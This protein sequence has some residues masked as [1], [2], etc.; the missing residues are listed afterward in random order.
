M[1]QQNE[2]QTWVVV[3]WCESPETEPGCFGKFFATYDDAWEF[4][5]TD[6]RQFKKR[7]RIG[8]KLGID[9]DYGHISLDWCGII[10]H[11]SLEQLSKG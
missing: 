1:A 9:E 6:A 2:T 3:N 4:A 10:H 11:W 5:K 8:G 7:N